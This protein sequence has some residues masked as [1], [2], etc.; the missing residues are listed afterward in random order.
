M[1]GKLS[2]NL[3]LGIPCL[4]DM[5]IVPSII[6]GHLKYEY[7]GK[8]PTIIRDPEP[9]SFCNLSDFDMEGLDLHCPKFHIV[10]LEV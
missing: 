1:S 2:Y 10:P 6:H 7:E 3:I 9:Y 5:D 8:M 4:D